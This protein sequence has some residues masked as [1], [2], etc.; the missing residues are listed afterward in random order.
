LSARVG[1]EDRRRS[2]ESSTTAPYVEAT[3]RYDYSGQSFVSA[4][5]T[6]SL[7]ETDNPT[8]Y[9]DSKMNQFFVNVQ[10]ALSA[11]I[12]TSASVTVAPAQLQGRPGW[13][14]A[15]TRQRPGLASRSH[16][17]RAGISR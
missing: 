13:P 2:G 6:Y 11:A 12:V 3:C 4:G 17:W 1:A 9:T 10:H 16:T 7:V 5:Y 8:L 15:F 14:T